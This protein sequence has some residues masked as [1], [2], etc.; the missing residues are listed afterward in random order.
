MKYIALSLFVFTIFG[1]SNLENNNVK[2]EYS[3]KESQKLSFVIDSNTNY[4]TLMIQ[5]FEENLAIESRENN[6][7]Q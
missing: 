5:S 1:C 3:L 4:K 2:H 6:S 7:I